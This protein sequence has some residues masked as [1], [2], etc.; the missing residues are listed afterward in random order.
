MGSEDI[1]YAAWHR[2]IRDRVLEKLSDY[3]H[4]KEESHIKM[5]K[6]FIEVMNKAV[7][8]GEIE[9]RTWD[10]SMLNGTTYNYT[11][12]ILTVEFKNGVEYSYQN[13]NREEYQKFLDSESKGK[14]FISEIRDKK[15]YKR[16]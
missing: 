16:L 5:E 8:S 11:E 13:I 2:G 7:T 3:N 14:H 4:L 9:S 10:S 1:L 15:E 12:E 6:A